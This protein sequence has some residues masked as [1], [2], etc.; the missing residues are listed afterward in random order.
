MLRRAQLYMTAEVEP[1]TVG[2]SMDTTFKFDTVLNL[3]SD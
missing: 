2:A 1:W 3:D